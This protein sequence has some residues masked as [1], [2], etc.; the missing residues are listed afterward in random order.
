MALMYRIAMVNVPHGKL[1]PLEKLLR[2][3]NWAPALSWPLDIC[4]TALWTRLVDGQPRRQTDAVAPVRGDVG[5]QQQSKHAPRA[6]SSSIPQHLPLG[7]AHR[8]K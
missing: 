7:R 3:S 4:R 8:G 5:R 1:A 6:T 2:V